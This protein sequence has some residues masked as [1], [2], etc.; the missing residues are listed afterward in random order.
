MSFEKFCDLYPNDFQFCT[1]KE[2]YKYLHDIARKYGN[3]TVKDFWKHEKLECK[4]N[5]IILDINFLK[6][7]KQLSVYPKILNFKLPNVS[8]KDALSIRTRLLRCA[9]N[10][11]NKEL[12]HLSKELSLSEKNLCTQ[13]STL[14][15]YILT[16]SITSY[17]KKSLLKSLNGQRKKLSSLT[18]DCDLPIFTAN[19]TIA[20]LTQH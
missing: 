6:N 16:K 12:E 10:K 4:K 8:N 11:G 13:L 17:N 15:F 3:F 2:N 20:N 7:Y 5:K 1:V 18:R 19:E 14:V 9:I